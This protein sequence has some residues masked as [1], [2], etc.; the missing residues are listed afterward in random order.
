MKI[1]LRYEEHDDEDLHLTLRLT[2]P[3]KYVDGLTK[4][5]CDLFVKQYNNKHGAANTLDAEK[6]HLKVAGGDH[7]AK[8]VVMKEY[9]SEGDE[10]YVMST[11]DN[12]QPVAKKPTL[13]APPPAAKSSAYSAPPAPK[14]PEPAKPSGSSAKVREDGKVRCKRFGCNRWFDP[15]DDKVPCRYHVAPPIFH[16]TAK[17]WSCCTEKKAYDWDSFMRIPGCQEG[18]CSVDPPEQRGQ[19]TVLGGADLRGQSAPERIDGPM[20]PQTSFNQ[21][22][23]GFKAMGVEV[24]LLDKALGT[25][26]GKHQSAS[27]PD[28]EAVRSK[29]KQEMENALLSLV[30]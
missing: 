10:L 29:M 23:R 5:V 2:L 30:K 25:L 19:K 11:F 3:K 26:A 24:E 18:Y 17:W 20:N 12:N 14:A 7:L 8:D 16:E 13:A 15:K 21:L 28:L 1:L 22:A 4:N 9:V 27:G 6:F